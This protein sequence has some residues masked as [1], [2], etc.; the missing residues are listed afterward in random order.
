MTS[1]SISVALVL[2]LINLN[3]FNLP[4]IRDQHRSLSPRSQT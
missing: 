4:L 2:K 3:V 1:Q